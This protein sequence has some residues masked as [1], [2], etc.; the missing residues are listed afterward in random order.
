M[1]TSR[2]RVIYAPRIT[3]PSFAVFAMPHM[4]VPSIDIFYDPN[5]YACTDCTYAVRKRAGLLSIAH[6]NNALSAFDLEFGSFN[7]QG[8][9]QT[10]TLHALCLASLPGS[11]VNLES[12]PQWNATLAEMQDAYDVVEVLSDWVRNLRATDLRPFT[13]NQSN[14][15]VVAQN[16]VAFLADLQPNYDIQVFVDDMETIPARGNSCAK[17]FSACSTV[18]T[19]TG[20]LHFNTLDGKQVTVRYRLKS[21][22]VPLP[23]VNVTFFDASNEI[24]TIPFETFYMDQIRTKVNIY[25]IFDFDRAGCGS[26][27]PLAGSPPS[28]LGIPLGVSFRLTRPR[29]VPQ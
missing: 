2:R 15:P 12:N 1:I 6:D 19:R 14:L 5:G 28:F 16:I 10:Q 27:S 7:L 25:N 4:N 11:C 20:Q 17:N 3:I 9:I 18:E 26:T 13:R 21:D 22:D 24:T 8:L 23:P 29:G